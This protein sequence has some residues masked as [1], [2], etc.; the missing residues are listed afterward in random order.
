MI[1]T[2]A[3]IAAIA[4]KKKKLQRSQR[5]YETT[6]QR[7]QRQQSLRY[8]K[9]YLSDRCRCDRW[10]VV[11]IW[12]LNFFF[13]AIAA[14]TAIVA[15]I[16]KPGLI[17]RNNH[18]PFLLNC[19]LYFLQTYQTYSSK[20]RLLLGLKGTMAFLS[21]LHKGAQHCLNATYLKFLTSHYCL[22]LILSHES[23]SYWCSTAWQRFGLFNT[24]FLANSSTAVFLHLGGF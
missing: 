7:S 13:S 22:E 3:V 20:L 2:I 19:Y 16:W 14:I 10:R 18:P 15:I 1:A 11:S 23:W 4:E 5:S 12:S 21:E 17:Y 9:F 8:K 6:L 24:H